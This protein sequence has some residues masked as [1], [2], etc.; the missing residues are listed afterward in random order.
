VPEYLLSR[1]INSHAALRAMTKHNDRQSVLVWYAAGG[2]PPGAAKY[3]YFDATDVTADDDVDVIKPTDIGGGSPGRWL[4]LPIAGDE[5]SG[6]AWYDGAGA[7]AGGLGEDG[8][9]YL[10]TSNG[11]VYSKVAGVWGV[12]GNIMGPTGAAGD[13][14]LSGSGVPGGGL[15][16]DGDHYLNT[17][18][19]DVYLKVGGSWGSPVGNIKGPQGPSFV[20]ISWAYADQVVASENYRIERYIHK[21]ANTDLTKFGGH[22]VTRPVSGDV[23]IVW[24]RNTVVVATLVYDWDGANDYQEVT[25]GAV[26]MTDGDELH[27]EI[28]TVAGS[29]GGVTLSMKARP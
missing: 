3:F 21:G 27:P 26:T 19:G 11:D 23:T 7:P 22:Y 6:S 14:F 9:Y 29:T 18:N 20:Q 5:S 15:G 13:T 17:A 4:T 25:V 24:K 10:R 16:N 8:D 12:I 2:E 28:S 1:I